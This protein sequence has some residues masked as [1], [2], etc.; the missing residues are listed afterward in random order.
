MAQCMVCG[1]TL[2]ENEIGLYLRMVNRAATE[3]LCK[4]C[5]A[6]KFSCEEER[7]DQKIWQFRSSG[8]TLFPP[9]SPEERAAGYISSKSGA[10]V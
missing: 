4:S 1:R 9:L 8:C 10:S 6:E 5:L 3:F 2:T 7:L